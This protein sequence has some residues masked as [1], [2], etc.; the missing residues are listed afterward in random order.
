MNK[1]FDNWEDIIVDNEALEEALKS[2]NVPA[3]MLAMVHLTGDASII[4]GETR[5]DYSIL[6]D[7]SV[8]ISLE[9]QAAIRAKALEVLKAYRDG[10]CKT[11]ETLSTEVIREMLRFITTSDLPEEYIEFVEGDL[12]LKGEDPYQQPGMDSL[13]EEKRKAFH[14]V[15]IGAG[16]S[17][18]LAAYRLKE[19]DIPYT[20]IEKNRAVGGTWLENTY[21]GCRVDSPNHTYSYSFLP[22]DW[23]QYYSPQKTL[24]GYFQDFASESGV[25]ERVR[26]NTEVKSVVYDENDSEWTITVK[27]ADGVYAIRANAVIGAVGQLNRHKLPEI[28]GRD[29]FRG[30][31]F[32]TARWDHGHDLSGKRIGVIGTGASAFQSVPEIAKK[33]KDVFI[34]QRTPPWISIRPEY[35]DYVP[36]NKHWLLHH[37][38]F[39]A[40]WF[41]FYIFCMGMQ[42]V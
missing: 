20:V 36:D 16:M 41:R 1:A 7:P 12:S 39:Y 25:Q 37:V 9:E 5:P 23:P 8:G 35:H 13:P 27:T 17:G 4:R 31:A 19:A 11:P 28:E 38:P 2:S 10:G 3:L 22:K 24:L 42:Y 40:K 21:P 34:F 32:H 33:A 6:G 14:V 26:F 15:I 18:L 30:P 29:T